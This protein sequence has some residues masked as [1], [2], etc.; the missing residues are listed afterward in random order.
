MIELLGVIAVIAI[1]AVAVTA[2]VIRRVDQGYI[3]REIADLKTI[4]DAYVQSCL[5]NKRIPS[6]NDWAANVATQIAMPVN[7]VLQTGRKTTR[8]F[9]VDPN[10]TIGGGTLPYTQSTAGTSV[11]ANA[12]VLVASSQSGSVAASFDTLWNT[13]DTDDVHIQRLELGRLFHKLHLHNTDINP[14]WHSIETNAPYSV[15]PS[16]GT[17]TLYVLEGTAVNLY[18]GTISTLQLREIMIEDQS[19]VYQQGRWARDLTSARFDSTLGAFGQLVQQ[20]LAAPSPPATESQLKGATQQAV[21]EAFYNY[22]VG[23]VLWAKGSPG[24]F[25]PWQGGG[26]TAAPQ[27]PY[28]KQLTEAQNAF[29]NNNLSDNLIHW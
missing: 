2:T 14:G 6:T 9:L 8:L 16:G 7:R 15:A 3:N 21:V 18:A 10:L 5:R 13:P 28:L 23:Y 12:R 19:F 4:G 17:R 11:P 29:D 24:I 1:I 22:M 25:G 26:Q 27:Y 20:F